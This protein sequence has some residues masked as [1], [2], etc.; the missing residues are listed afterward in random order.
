[1]KVVVDNDL[2]LRYF[3]HLVAA[4]GGMPEV[5]TAPGAAAF[6]TALFDV[7]VASAFA[8][9]R[10]SVADHQD[11]IDAWVQYTLVVL[12]DIIRNLKPAPVTRLTVVP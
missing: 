1:M 5:S 3:D 11:T 12:G 9:N 10:I 8:A 2:R 4:I 6:V 7:A